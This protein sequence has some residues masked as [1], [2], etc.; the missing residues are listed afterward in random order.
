[1]KLF[2]FIRDHMLIQRYPTVKQLVKFGFVGSFVTVIDFSIYFTLTRL[3]VWWGEHFLI[4]NGVAFLTAL[5]TSFFLNK[6]WTFRNDHKAYRKQSAKFFLS[7]LIALGGTQGILYI[8]VGLLEWSDIIAKPLAVGV[9]VFWNFLS[10]KYW[11]F[12]NNRH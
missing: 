10:Y 1:M 5:T 2:S 7:N 3:F 6:F 8:L 12:P 11:V 4:A 9:I